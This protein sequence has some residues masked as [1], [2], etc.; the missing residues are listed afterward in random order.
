MLGKTNAT[1]STGG[2]GGGATVQAVN[3]T[4]SAISSGDK[5]WINKK[6]VG[7]QFDVSTQTYLY[8]NNLDGSSV[9]CSDGYNYDLSS[10]SATIGN[11]FHSNI[12]SYFPNG[13]KY[14][15]N[16]SIFFAGS[17]MMM[18]I[19]RG[20]QWI[21]SKDT[22]YYIGENL[23]TSY[24]DNKIFMFDFDTMEDIKSF[25]IDSAD[26]SATRSGYHNVA[27]NGYIYYFSDVNYIIYR[28]R[29]DN[30]ND[31][32]TLIYEQ[33][34]TFTNYFHPAGITQDGKYIIGAKTSS[35]GLIGELRI[36]EIK[37]DGVAEMDYTNFPNQYVL[38]N[39]GIIVFNPYNGTIC[40]ATNG[41]TPTM[42][43]Y[44]DGKF[45]DLNIQFGATNYMVMSTDL[46]IS[47]VAVSVR[48]SSSSYKCK[49][50]NLNI[51]NPT[52]ILQNFDKISTDTVTGKAN[53]DIPSGQSGEVSTVL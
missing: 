11:R 26:N 12:F 15:P 36:F 25:N 6:V 3:K 35:N 18:R 50:I 34:G 45:Y 2:S 32:D 53:Q 41:E 42:L 48:E 7:S 30:L 44:K 46:N 24:H 16:N 28:A 13:I 29:Y 49:I 20:L 21:A 37:A 10:D 39:G 38:S 52:Y 40:S 14:G 1:V 23:Y 17:H 33:V 19:D 5:V 4:G 27:H 51:D 8:M 22:C 31:G 9:I 43:Q 47:R